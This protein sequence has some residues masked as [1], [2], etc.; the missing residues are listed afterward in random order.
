MKQFECKKMQKKIKLAS[1]AATSKS[2]NIINH[3]GNKTKDLPEN[4]SVKDIW[5]EFTDEVWYPA[6]QGVSFEQAKANKPSTKLFDFVKL[7]RNMKVVST[8]ISGIKE[9]DMIEGFDSSTGGLMRMHWIDRNNDYNM[10]QEEANPRINGKR[11]FSPC[12]MMIRSFLEYFAST[13]YL[14]PPSKKSKMWKAS[15]KE[16]EDQLESFSNKLYGTHLKRDKLQSLLSLS[17]NLPNHRDVG[18]NDLRFR[19]QVFR[20]PDDMVKDIQTFFGDSSQ[21]V[22]SA[23]IEKNE[24]YW[25]VHDLV[26]FHTRVKGTTSLNKKTN[27]KAPVMTF[28]RG[29]WKVVK[30]LI[31]NKKEPDIVLEKEGNIYCICKDG[32]NIH[33]KVSASNFNS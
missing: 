16:R 7:E 25:H 32:G 11:F 21:D 28:R 12:R 19:M 3:S 10:V 9:G 8:N 30:T 29:V 26:S 4:Y 1:T 18:G 27:E 17:D 22:I 15:K 6:S 24:P 2:S 23:L 33:I 31:D 14:S 13:E 5:N 20:L